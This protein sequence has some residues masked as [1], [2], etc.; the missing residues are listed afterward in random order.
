MPNQSHLLSSRTGQTFS[1]TGLFLLLLDGAET[2][3]ALGRGGACPTLVCGLVL[4]DFVF[5]SVV[6]VHSAALELVRCHHA[7]LD[8]QQ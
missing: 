5:S 4:V 3:F 6:E 8:V 1:L 7:M 2:S